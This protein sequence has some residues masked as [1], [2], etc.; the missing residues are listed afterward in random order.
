MHEVLE[1]KR[2]AKLKKRVA[3]KEKWR[4]RLFLKPKPPKWCIEDEQD[5]RGKVIFVRMKRSGVSRSVEFTLDG[6]VYRW[7][8][9]RMF[10]GWIKGWSH[11][12]KVRKGR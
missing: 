11:N 4:K 5:V 2:R 3:F 10:G 7:S 12:M 9:T 1:N 6:E 8:G